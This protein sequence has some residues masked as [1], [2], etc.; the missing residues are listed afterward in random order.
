MIFILSRIEGKFIT[1]GSKLG[2]AGFIE[3][4]KLLVDNKLIS[5]NGE[6]LVIEK[7][8]IEETA[9]PVDVYNFQVEHYHTYFVGENKV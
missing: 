7:F 4:G 5:I 6:D 2:N 9:E 3:A 1:C 8:L